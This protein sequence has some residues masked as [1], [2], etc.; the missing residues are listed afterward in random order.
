MAYV[1]HSTDSSQSCPSPDQP[2]PLATTAVQRCAL[3]SVSD[4]PCD[5][6]ADTTSFPLTEVDIM[7]PVAFGD[8]LN[9]Q[10]IVGEKQ[11]KE[12]LSLAHTNTRRSATEG[13]DHMGLVAR[14]RVAASEAEREREERERKRRKE[15]EEGVGE[16]AERVMKEKMDE[17][18]KSLERSDIDGNQRKNKESSRVRTSREERLQVKTHEEGEADLKTKIEGSIWGETV[19]DEAGGRQRNEEASI[20]VSSMSPKKH[21]TAN[22][23]SHDCPPLK[24]VVFDFDQSEDGSG[25]KATNKTHLK[26]AF[27]FRPN[28]AADSS[29]SV[30]EHVP[31]KPKVSRPNKA[32][33]ISG[34]GVQ[35][36]PPKSSKTV[37][38]ALRRPAV[39]DVP[40]WMRKE[41]NEELVYEMGQ[42]DIG[43]IWSA[44]LYMEGGG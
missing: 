11:P 12:E 2:G 36:V 28:N 41:D 30:G 5:S 9:R 31:L 24:E 10:P 40:V 43:T 35:E 34:D 27:K 25:P 17:A 38:S 44:E 15:S 32:F 33:H 6:E 39:P 21:N 20:T 19:W 22:S 23:Q 18:E 13:L 8:V 42:E 37:H 7:P 16:R 4:L 1:F 26:D 3:R 29:V 14:L